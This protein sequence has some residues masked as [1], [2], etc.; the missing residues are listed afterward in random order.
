LYFPALTIVW[1]TPAW[2]SAALTSVCT[3]NTPI[4]P[5]HALGLATISSAWAASQ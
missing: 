2:A 1:R 5:T 3:M 4:E